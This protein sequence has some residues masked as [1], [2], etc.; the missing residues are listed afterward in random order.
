MFAETEAKKKKSSIKAALTKMKTAV[1][2]LEYN[3][4]KR[5]NVKQIETKLTNLD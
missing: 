3:G 2:T 5:L 1:K 4:L